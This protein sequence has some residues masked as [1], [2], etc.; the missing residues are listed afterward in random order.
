M[1]KFVRLVDSANEWMGRAMRWVIMIA[2]GFTCFE[3]F[4]RYVFN[5]PTMWGYEVPIHLGAAFYTLAWGFV[6][7]HKGH[8]R[9]DVFYAKYSDRGRAIVDIVCFFVL[10]LPV[11]GVLTY[12]SADWMIH[13]WAIAERSNMTY[14]YPPIS[15]LRT[16]IFIGILLFLLQGIAQLWRDVHF[17]ARGEHLD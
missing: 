1:T 12:T 4:Q 13:A 5:H 16:A 8:V 14:W 10:F 11:V 6:L 15:P 17:L 9:V 3:V 7:L 2:I